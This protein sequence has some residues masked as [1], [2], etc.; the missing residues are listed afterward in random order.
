MKLKNFLK[1]SIKPTYI[2]KGLRNPKKIIKYLTKDLIIEPGEFI[3][4]LTGENLLEI[5]RYIKEINGKEEFNDYI[6]KN[7]KNFESRLHKEKR[8][9]IGGGVTKD[10]GIIFYTIVRLLEP[11]IVLE[12]GVASGISSAYILSA[13]E[14]NKHGQLFSIDLPYKENKQYF[15]DYVKS[16]GRVLIPDDREPG[17]LIPEDLKKRW[18]LELGKSSE[19]L[20]PVIKNLP[21]IDIF[22]HDSEHTYENMIW[23]FRTVWPYLKK[24]GLLLSH[25]INWN[26]AFSDFYK[27]IKGNGVI[28]KESFGGV[29][30]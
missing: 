13:L 7:Y 25:D 30:K 2:V 24:E 3:V 9:S 10:E 26:K 12:T 22:I 8:Q 4:K 23:E 11:N 5:N 15:S 21:L 17:W 14:E 20:P 27:E 16:G 6:W 1:Y 29:K 28:Y 18:R 19:K